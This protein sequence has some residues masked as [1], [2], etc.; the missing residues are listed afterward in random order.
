MPA[1]LHFPDALKNVPGDHASALMEFCLACCN[2]LL[3]YPTESMT[4][5]RAKTPR[6][7]ISAFLNA[8][9]KSMKR[10]LQNWHSTYSSSKWRTKFNNTS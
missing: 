6:I 2:K 10:P 3:N 9:E 4:Y 5:E 8:L 7:V 1:P